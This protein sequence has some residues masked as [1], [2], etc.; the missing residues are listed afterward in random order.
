MNLRPRTLL[1]SSH[2]S[3]TI[4]ASTI[5]P[6]SSRLLTAYEPKPALSSISLA[7]DFLSS[8]R[9]DH[10]AASDILIALAEQRHSAR[11]NRKAFH[12][13]RRTFVNIRPPTGGRT[14]FRNTAFSPC[15]TL[16]PRRC[17]LRL[18]DRQAATE[19]NPLRHRIVAEAIR[20]DSMVCSAFRGRIRALLPRA[21]LQATCRCQNL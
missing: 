7:P 1:P 8:P 13:R 2:L 14:P 17:L 6:P 16:A 10:S 4:S 9:D 20:K 19:R 21:P 15:A 5:L 11:S 3:T 12:R 18:R